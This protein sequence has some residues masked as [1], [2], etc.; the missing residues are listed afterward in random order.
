MA[1]TPADIIERTIHIDALPPTVFSFF[2][3]PAKMIEWH[4]VEADLD[5]RPGGL[6]RVNI[7]GGNVARGTF[8]EVSPYTR[9]VFTWG[10]EGDDSTVP[11]GASTVEV[12]LTPD[13]GGTLVRLIHRDL[14]TQAVTGHTQGWDHYLPRLAARAT[15][16]DPGPDSWAQEHQP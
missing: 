2:T 11:P 4:G 1:A 14:P 13:G 12:T 9:V 15:G 16:R 7:T 8:V 6:Y 5:A 3:D 10:W